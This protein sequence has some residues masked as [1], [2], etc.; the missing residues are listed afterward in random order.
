M[1][2]F[3]KENAI[4]PVAKLTPEQVEEQFRELYQAEQASF[5]LSVADVA[6]RI[7]LSKRS[8]QRL[9]AGETRF[10]AALLVAIGNALGINKSRATFVVEHFQD[11]RRYSDPTLIVA[12]DLI[13]PV[14]AMIIESGSP[15]IEPLQPQVN[16]QLAKWISL[17][18]IEH[19]EKVCARRAELDLIRAH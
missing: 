3:K 17:M 11:W 19:H 1:E 9:L 4:K 15:A 7:G 8:Y 6:R 10:I 12:F 2:L 14:V 5:E 18:I 13:K 16:E